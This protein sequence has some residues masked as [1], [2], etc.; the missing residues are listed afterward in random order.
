MGTENTVSEGEF[1]GYQD[2]AAYYDLIMGDRQPF[3]DFYLSLL[4]PSDRSV[5]DIG[6]GSGSVTAAMARALRESDGGGKVRIAGI[7]GSQAMLAAAAR[8]DAA[9]AWILGD[10]R[11]LP[12]AGPFDLAICTYNTY[13]HVDMEGLRQAFCSARSILRAG[14]RL[15]FDIYQPKLDYIRIPQRS[16]LAFSILHDDGR[17]L[18]VREN[19]DYDE[20]SRILLVDWTLREAD[21]AQALPLAHTRYRMWQHPPHEVENALADA[22]LVIEERYG[23][24]DRAPFDHASKKQVVVCRAV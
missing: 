12:V 3:I 2:L 9:V 11:D 21:D 8:R 10:I 19:T 5:L 4:T 14:G 16:R 24:L 1:A 17:P 7:D 20:A 23:G 15:A 6:C 22:S 18:E 13:Q